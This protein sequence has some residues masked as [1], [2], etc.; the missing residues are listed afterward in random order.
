MATQSITAQSSDEK[1]SVTFE[2]TYASPLYVYNAVRGNGDVWT[3]VECPN[4]D[5]RKSGYSMRY[6]LLRN[7]VEYCKPPGNSARVVLSVACDCIQA[8][9]E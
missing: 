8:L 1:L 7:G 4:P 3:V 9:E 5:A 2:R 6:S